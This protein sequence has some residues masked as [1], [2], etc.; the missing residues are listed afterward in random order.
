MRL[1]VPR[2]TERL[3][4]VVIHGMQRVYELDSGMGS[5]EPTGGSDPLM[6]RVP[7]E[8][9]YNIE[10]D[11]A[12]VVPVRNDRI[13]LV[14]GVLSG[15]PNHCQ[16]IILSNSPRYP[17]DRFALEQ[18]AF[19]RYSRFTN[20]RVLVAHQKDPLFGKACLAAGYEAIVDPQTGLV[21]DGKAEGMILATLMA[22]LAGKRYI[23]F[24]DADNY[25]PGAVLEYI[26]EYSSGL[27]TTEG[28]YRMIRIAWHSKPKI[29]ESNLFF[30]KWGR[31]SRRTNRYLNMLLGEYS[32]FET[33]IIR[34][35]NAGEHAMT[36]DLAMTL[37]Y[38]SGYSIEPFHFI[39]M[40]EKFGG[41]TEA[42]LP[43]QLI[44][45][46]VSIYQIQSRNPHMHD[47]AKGEGHIDHMSLAAMQ[48]IY[49]STICPSNLRQELLKGMHA[50]GMVTE[51]EPPSVMRYPALDT[52]DLSAFAATIEGAAYSSLLMA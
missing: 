48:V 44:E 30:A 5:G 41:L 1:E 21:R 34:T 12:I 3:G 32:G 16:T 9:K 31:T 20:K 52:V 26:R 18:D 4:A 43:R 10:K 17:V 47:A 22:R 23:G 39:S 29:V 45:A 6:Q 37:D 35:G 7:Y 2:E 42:T 15:I 46:H 14:E 27:A 40:F 19:R 8:Q 38:S 49:H 24:I 36:I 13:K 50:L 25:F 51:G 33:D 11:M 28:L